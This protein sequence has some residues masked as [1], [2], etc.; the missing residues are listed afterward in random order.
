MADLWNVGSWLPADVGREVHRVEER[1]GFN[2]IC[3]VSSKPVL[4]STAELGDE[5]SCLRA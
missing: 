1:M 4:S 2:I 3:S 5:I